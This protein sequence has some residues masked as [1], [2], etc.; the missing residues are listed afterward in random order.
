MGDIDSSARSQFNIPDRVRGALIT[1]VEP[2][3]ASYDAGLRPGDV[4]LEIDHKRVT[5]AEEAVEVS[6][7]VKSKQVLVRLWSRGGSRFV[8]VNEGK[9]K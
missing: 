5:N 8:V 7:H 4:I 3:S 1:E 2:D 6:K 9:S